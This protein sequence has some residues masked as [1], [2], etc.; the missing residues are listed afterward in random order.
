[1]A[2]QG[3][4]SSGWSMVSRNK[5]YIIWFYVLNVTLAEFGASAFREQ[6]H[7]MLDHSM[8]ADRLVNGFHPAVLLEMLVRPEFGSSRGSSWPAIFF[9]LLYFVFSALFV[10]G[11]LA[12]YASTYRLPRDEFFRACGRNLWRFI[13]ILIIAGIVMGVVGGIL[14]GIHGALMKAAGESTNEWMPYYVSWAGLLVIFLVMATLRIWFDLAEADTVLSDQRAVRKSIGVGFRHTWRA[15]GRLLGSYVVTTI[16]AL[17]ILVGGLWAWLTFVPPASVVGAFFMGQLT[18][19]LLLIPRFWQR[20]V[21]VTYYKQN[22]I[23]P[24]VEESFAPAP[25]V[26]Q[27]TPVDTPAA[28]PAMPNVPP[29]TQAS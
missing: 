7:S 12:G 9:A 11:I 20:G 2:N 13:R 27:V 24:I 14:F 1:M 25:I 29:A 4:L 17:I 28:T 18:L 8:A 19:L 16:V 6:A 22:M 26:A 15:L 23:A 5:R 3:L 10:P 21:A